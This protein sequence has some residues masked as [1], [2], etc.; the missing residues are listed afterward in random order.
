MNFA[1]LASRKFA[2]AD[3]PKTSSHRLLKTCNLS[4][5]V[6]TRMRPRSRSGPCPLRPDLDDWGTRSRSRASAH[7]RLRSS[8]SERLGFG[9][10]SSSMG[11]VSPTALKRLG[12]V[13]WLL[14]WLVSYY[15]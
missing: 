9:T 2:E 10:R 11:V 3:E 13:V 15:K 4:A 5:G 12:Y 8:D 14:C 1:E 6:A 7:N